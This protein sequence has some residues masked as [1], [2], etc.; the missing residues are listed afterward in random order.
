MFQHELVSLEGAEE[1]LVG[2]RQE[3]QEWK[4]KIEDLGAQKR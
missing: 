1:E 4:G 2:S 3:I